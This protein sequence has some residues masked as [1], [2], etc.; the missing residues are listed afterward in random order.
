MYPNHCSTCKFFFRIICLICSIDE[1]VTRFHMQTLL[2]EL[3]DQ[4]LLGGRLFSFYHFFGDLFVVELSKILNASHVCFLTV[5]V[6]K[7][8]KRMHLYNWKLISIK[9]RFSLNIGK[10][11]EVKWIESFYLQKS[12]NASWSWES[13][14]LLTGVRFNAFYH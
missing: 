12:L 7:I 8:R 5:I 4:S 2:S 14:T 13:E 11:C 9:M 10:R 3:F 6:K 1:F